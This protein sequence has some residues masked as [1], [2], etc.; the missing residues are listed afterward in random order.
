MRK[1]TAF[2]VLALVATP[3]A[4]SDWRDVG[5]NTSGSQYWIDASSKT[6]SAEGIVVWV[7]VNYGTPGPNGTSSYK[8]HREI[9]C[10]GK[11]FRDLETTYFKGTDVNSRS[12]VEEWRNASPDS[13]AEAVVDKACAL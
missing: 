6:R 1:T 2:L 11:S 10:A 8:A 4:A 13:I 9:R 5:K 3:A 7:K 12:G